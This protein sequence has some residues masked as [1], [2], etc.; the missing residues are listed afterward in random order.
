[1][2]RTSRDLVVVD[3]TDPLVELSEWFSTRTG[4]L[5]GKSLWANAIIDDSTG[6]AAFVIELPGGSPHLLQS[7]GYIQRPRYQVDVRS[8]G[9]TKGDYPNPTAA[10]ALARRLFQACLDLT[11][12]YRTASSSTSP[13]HWIFA[14]P[15]QE[16]YLAGRDSKNRLVFRFDVGCERQGS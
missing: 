8:T 11:D 13:G 12:E 5:V 16:P 14:T 15:E 6:V 7:T 3:M 9:P 2:Q 4:V 1:M 10:R